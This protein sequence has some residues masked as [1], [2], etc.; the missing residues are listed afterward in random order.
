MKIHQKGC[1]HNKIYHPRHSLIDSNKTKSV[2]SS[3][4]REDIAKIHEEDLQRKNWIIRLKY[5]TL[6]KSPPVYPAGW[7][8]LRLPSQGCHTYKFLYYALNI[9]GFDTN[10][11]SDTRQREILGL[12]SHEWTLINTGFKSQK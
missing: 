8:A 4:A 11:H 10:H 2:I 3:E 1:Y 5:L 9:T 12:F 6:S 7:L